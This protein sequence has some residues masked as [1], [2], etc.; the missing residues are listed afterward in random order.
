MN[1]KGIGPQ[2]IVGIF[3]MF[4]MLWALLEPMRL[5][6]GKLVGTGGA[7]GTIYGLI[8]IV[9]AVMILAGMV[10]IAGSKGGG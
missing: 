5:V 9:L 10:N 6:V 3:I 1:K 8:P 4:L 7:S 2:S